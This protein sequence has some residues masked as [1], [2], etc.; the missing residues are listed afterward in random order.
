VEESGTGASHRQGVLK[1]R[2]CRW[3]AVEKAREAA[4]H[5]RVRDEES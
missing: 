2:Q 3:K 5:T 1:R 4:P